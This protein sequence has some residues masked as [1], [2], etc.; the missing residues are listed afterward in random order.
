MEKPKIPPKIRSIL[1]PALAP[2]LPSPIPTARGSRSAADPILSGHINA[3]VQ[4]PELKLPQQAHR[5]RPEEID[6]RRLASGESDS[7]RRLLGSIVEFG[8]VII[9]DHGISTAEELRFALDNGERVFGLAAICCSS[10]GDHERIVWRGDD[11]RIVEEATAA[12]G[13]R[14]FQMLC[15]NLKNVSGQLE[16]VAQKVAMAIASNDRTQIQEHIHLGESTLS[17][18]RYHR[19]HIINRISSDKSSRDQSAPYALSLHLF[20]EPTELS[21]GTGWENLSFQT[22]PD[23][24]VVATGKELEEKSVGEFISAQERLMH[25]PFLHTN[26]PSFSIEQKW[27]NSRF[28]GE[29][30]K[31]IS[32]A[33]QIL[34]LLIVAI[35]YRS[36][37]Y[38]FA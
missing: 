26:R 3:S 21:I 12:I 8:V 23:T 14:D 18:Y 30:N 5:L 19:A 38:M 10:Y 2:P 7:V 22:G 28:G 25:R 6:F 33:D 24:I 36:F 11:R 32:M 29:S 17:I 16:E 1:S 27:S 13:G 20:L 9:R 4:I 37:S 15:Q 31:T 34:T 35:L